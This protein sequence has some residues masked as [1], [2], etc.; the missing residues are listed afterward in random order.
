ME[1]QIPYLFHTQIPQTDYLQADF[2]VYRPNYPDIMCEKE[3]G[4]NR[5]SNDVRSY[6]PLCV[7]FAEVLRLRIYEISKEQS[8]DLRPSRE[9][10]VQVW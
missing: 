8:Y 4:Y 9:S 5:S 1:L 6:S 2:S 7:D 10:Q 3:R